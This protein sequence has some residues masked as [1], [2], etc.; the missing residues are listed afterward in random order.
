MLIVS[1]VV[2][3]QLPSCTS[4]YVRLSRISITMLELVA[5]LKIQLIRIGPIRIEHCLSHNA[6]APLHEAELQLCGMA[7][8]FVLGPD[9]GRTWLPQL[10]C[11]V[12][13]LVPDGA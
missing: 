13:S 12:V 8:Q 10:S 2:Y 1:C 5:R 4:L 3:F 7:Q 11:N 6:K 9:M